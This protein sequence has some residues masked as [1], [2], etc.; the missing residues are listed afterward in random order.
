MSNALARAYSAFA[1]YAP[2]TLQSM[3]H[4]IELCN[5][6]AVV[7]QARTLEQLSTDAGAAEVGYGVAR[8]IRCL[9]EARRLAKSSEDAF[10]AAASEL[11]RLIDHLQGELNAFVSSRVVERY[12]EQDYRYT[13]DAAGLRT[14]RQPASHTKTLRSWNNTVYEARVAKAFFEEQLVCMQCAPPPRGSTCAR[15]A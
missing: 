10:I 11:S 3:R 9:R 2:G 14:T 12:Q 6:E 7:L 13:V 15:S 4:A 5:H 1:T 8:V